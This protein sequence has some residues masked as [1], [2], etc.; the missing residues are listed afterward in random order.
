MKE[1]LLSDESLNSYGFIV[2][3]AGIKMN[4]FVKNPIMFLN[5][6]RDKGLIG[7]WESLR[8]DGTSLYGTPVF[9]DVHEPGKTTKE[10][11][12]GGFLNGASI[13]IGECVI[14]VINGFKTVVSCQLEEISICDIPSNMN[15]VQL[16]FKN[17]RVDLSTYIQLSK[18]KE[19][20]E[21]DLKEL[22]ELLGLNSEATIQNVIEAIK[23]LKQSSPVQTDTREALSLALQQGIITRDEQSSLTDLFNDNPGKLSIFLSIK[24]KSY[25]E[26]VKK[27][28]KELVESNR[29]KFRTYSHDYIYGD[30]LE[31]A[32]KDF[33]AFKN[34]ILKAPE[35]VTPM[36]LIN[37]DSKNGT[38][39][40]KSGWSLEDYRKNA[41]QELRNNP[42]LY[43]E[44]LEKEQTKH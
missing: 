10:Q 43:K 9:D 5:H 44:L 41:P 14:D 16:Y 2:L 12:E 21:N 19:M 34:M 13:G 6:D 38:I 1:F 17:N 37:S 25:Q 42:E 24:H 15:A 23:A 8:I 28:F 26:T 32:M 27:E 39:K 22:R 3:T 11:V 40:L 36:G 18:N 4:R 7:R 33:K 31:F 35:A 30:M 20:N 29:N